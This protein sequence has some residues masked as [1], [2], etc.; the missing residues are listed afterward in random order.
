M[1]ESKTKCAACSICGVVY[2]ENKLVELDGK[3]MCHE[4]LS[5]E[6]R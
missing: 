4:C 6:T 5:S 2:E 3:K 1:K